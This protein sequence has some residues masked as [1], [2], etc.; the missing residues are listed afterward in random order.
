VR[1]P[2]PTFKRRKVLPVHKKVIVEEP[3]R[4]KKRS[5]ESH[6][7]FCANAQYCTLGELP[8][9]LQFARKRANNNNIFSS[10][11]SSGGMIFPWI[12]WTGMKLALPS[13]SNNSYCSVDAYISMPLV[14]F[15]LAI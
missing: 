14:T 5:N 6:E 15:L 2:L 1:T 10:A 7:T 12:L 4:N 3:T 11:M 13:G 9:K 8:P